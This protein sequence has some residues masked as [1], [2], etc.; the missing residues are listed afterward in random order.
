[1]VVNKGAST[2]EIPQ[3]EVELTEVVF[4]ARARAHQ[5]STSLLLFIGGTT[6]P[7]QPGRI[8]LRHL[9]HLRERR[10]DLL[11]PGRSGGTT[12][13]PNASSRDRR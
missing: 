13:E 8:L 7:L 5:I 11:P 9:L 3:L 6:E 12:I 4:I 10:V 1:M 2:L